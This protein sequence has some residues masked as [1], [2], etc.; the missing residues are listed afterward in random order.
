MSDPA[1]Q[2]VPVQDT[3]AIIRAQSQRDADMASA[4]FRDPDVV[5]KSYAP[6]LRTSAD[7]L[8]D[9]TGMSESEVNT[10]LQDVATFFDDAGIT[11]DAAASLHSIMVHHLTNP[12]ED[13]T[14]D[15]W[16]TESRRLLREQYGA[17]DADRRLNAVRAFVDARPTLKG[18]LNQSGVGSHPRL[19]LALAER[20]QYL[21]P[22]RGKR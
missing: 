7:R 15:E 2:A 19:V 12:V 9:A 1:E 5:T 4:L 10:H 21:K 18:K 20:V 6:V 14:F 13:G 22:P 11:N 3:A 16:Q 8:R 17:A